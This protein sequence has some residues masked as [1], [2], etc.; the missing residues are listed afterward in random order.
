MIRALEASAQKERPDHAAYIEFF[1]RYRESLSSKDLAG[2]NGLWREL[3][4]S[5]MDCKL[6]VQV[7]HDIET[8]YGDPL[9]VKA[10]PDYSLRFLDETYAAENAQIAD[11]QRR[12]VGYFSGRNTTLAA[13]GL[14]ALSN[15]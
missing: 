15:T 4:R 5:W 10:T 2:L 13:Q 11:I 8:G 7:V 3:D 1:R 9:R 14:Q 6:P 12:L